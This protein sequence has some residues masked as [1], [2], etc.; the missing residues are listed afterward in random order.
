[1]DCWYLESSHRVFTPQTLA[2]ALDHTLSLPECRGLDTWLLLVLISSSALC[3]AH[4]LPVRGTAR[5]LPTSVCSISSLL[6]FSLFLSPQPFATWGQVAMR[7]A[8]CRVWLLR[9]TGSAA[10]VVAGPSACGCSSVRDLVWIYCVLSTH[11]QG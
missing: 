3:L 8:W 7:H 11:W 6:H 2:A 5:S 1:M 4:C 10:R 9:N